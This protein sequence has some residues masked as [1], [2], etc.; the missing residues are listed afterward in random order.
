VSAVGA[1]R[2]Y[3]KAS[4][5]A[6]RRSAAIERS[7]LPPGP[8]APFVVQS[9]RML[10]QRHTYV[11]ALHR[12]YGDVFTMWI[13][14]GPR[15]VVL[16]RR[17]EDIRQ[18]F[19]GDPRD[20]HAG[21]GNAILGPVMGDHSVLLTDE[22]QHLRARR[23][24][25]PAFNGAALRSYRSLV[26]SLAAEEVARWTPG[27]TIS[28]LQRMNALTLE[29]IL[30]VVFGV[31]EEHRLQLLRPR[32]TRIVDIGTSIL[33]GWIYPRL[34]RWG[35]W[36]TYADN[37]AELDRLLYAEIAERRTR[38]DLA[39]RGDVLSRL[40]SVGADQDEQPLSDAELRDQLVTLLLAGHET[41]ASALA[42]ALHELA[43]D[44]RQLARARQAC[45]DDDD[46]YLEAVLKESLRLH[47]VIAMVARV[48]QSPQRIG[49]YDLPAGVTVAP[50]ILLAHACPDS[51]PEPLAFRPERF[52]DASPAHST[53]IPFGGGVRR[54]LGAGFSLME[55]VAV[56]REVLA[57]YDLHAPAPERPRVRNITT[58]P[59][60]GAP[61]TPTPR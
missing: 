40:L 8:R 1:R 36:R 43:R 2:T 61:I 31:T 11:P 33:L 53:W 21:D 48:L 56:L 25:M 52:L 10:R 19:A 37:L 34:Q 5:D 30:Q 15:P 26:H 3:D 4:T 9:V 38:P 32:V 42:W 39:T 6:R 41:T 45:T 49:G 22:A 54:C 60:S 46:T 55:G 24:L 7:A 47:P 17:P 51:F 27:S 28:A 20:F 14:P 12:H 57:V 58:V 59:A 16:L 50:S 18:V 23:L 35:P 44:P 13:A 29:I